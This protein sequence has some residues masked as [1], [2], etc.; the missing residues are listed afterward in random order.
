MA[1]AKDDFFQVVS[2]QWTQLFLL[3]LC[4]EKFFISKDIWSYID[5]TSVKPTSKRD[6][7]KYTKK[8]KKNEILVIQKL[9]HWLIIM[10]NY[11]KCATNKI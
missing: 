10:L 6:E 5:G 3:E 7:A 2:V 8:L 4:D 9:L 1:D 11:Y